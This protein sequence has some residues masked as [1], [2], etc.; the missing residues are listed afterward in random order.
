[1]IALPRVPVICPAASLSG[2]GHAGLTPLHA[3][4]VRYLTREVSRATYKR[5][6]G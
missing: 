3:W 2:V 6:G 5:T 1:M 4:L